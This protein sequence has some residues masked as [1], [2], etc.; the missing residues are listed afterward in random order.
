[1]RNPDLTAREHLHLALADWAVAQNV[2]GQV[3][4]FSVAFPA[5]FGDDHVLD[6]ARMYEVPASALG[7]LLDADADARAG[8]APGGD[9]A[10]ANLRYGA[11]RLYYLL[12][13]DQPERSTR[14]SG[15][16]QPRDASEAFGELARLVEQVSALVEQ[17]DGII[18]RELRDGR[19]MP[20]LAAA[21]DQA[22]GRAATPAELEERLHGSAAAARARL[23][24]AAAQLR[25]MQLRA[26]GLCRAMQA[27]IVGPGDG[28]TLRDQYLVRCE[29]FGLPAAY[30][31][32]IFQPPRQR[33]LVIIGE[34]GDNHSTH[35]NNAAEA[36]ASAV[37]EHILQTRDES[38]AVWV[39]YEPAEQYYY[40]PGLDDASDSASGSGREDEAKILS[41]T[42]GFTDVDWRRI[43]HEKLEQLAGGPVRRW[44]VYDYTTAAITIAGAVPAE[45]TIPDRK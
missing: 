2:T 20:T 13:P 32:R 27:A 10:I 41:F 39:Q 33:P 17:A 29:P 38:A 43:D 45:L 7:N 28:P 21:V 24:E 42:P 8:R 44:H 35:V 36:I 30:H 37:S 4:T 31:V 18:G 5:E 26:R 40:S 34:L 22:R 16:P 11:A 12:G 23:G 3:S 1:M 6:P 15:W 14:C 9:D 25:R 19:L